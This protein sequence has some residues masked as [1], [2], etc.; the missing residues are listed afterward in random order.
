MG[1]V[2]CAA[3]AEA[4]SARK[5]G[6]QLF[7]EKGCTQCHTINGVGKHKGPNLSAVGKRLK[8]P[9]IEKQIV[10]GGLNMP[11]F[12]D[13]ITP[14]ETHDLVEYL[15]KCKRDLSGSTENAAASDSASAAAKAN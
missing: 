5:H 14:E 8:K 4:E 12:K 6:A 1:L 7:E 9:A 2:L 13:A 3:S 10:E 11:P 15:H